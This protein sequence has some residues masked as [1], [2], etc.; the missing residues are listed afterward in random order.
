MPAIRALLAACEEE[1]GAP[2]E[3]EFAIS[4]ERGRPP[5]FG[6]LQVRPLLVSHET[7]ELSDEELERGD[8]VIASR[9]ALGNGRRRLEDALVVDPET[10]EA[11]RTPDI[12]LELEQLNRPLVADGRPYLLIGYG[13]WGSS[14]PWLGIPVRWDQIAGARA[15]VEAALPQMSPDP[16]QGS[17]FFHNLS[18][19]DVLYL[20]VPANAPRGIDWRQLAGQPTVARTQHVRHLRLEP[21]LEVAVDG[22]SRRGVVRPQEN[23]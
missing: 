14:D 7:V 12:A 17:H 18:S 8:A 10:F 6:F 4:V 2:V 15:I 3:I 21:A 16:S 11:G 5:R 1:L 19:F 23:R 13:R 22:R 9:D 20:T